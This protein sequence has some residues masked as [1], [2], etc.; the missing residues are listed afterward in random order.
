MIITIIINI[1]PNKKERKNDDQRSN[2][3]LAWIISELR[4]GSSQLMCRPSFILGWSFKLHE[5]KNYMKN[6]MK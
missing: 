6:Y 1:K 3:K 2:V 5:I 4:V